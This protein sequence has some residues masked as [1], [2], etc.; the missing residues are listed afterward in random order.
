[1]ILSLSI[2]KKAVPRDG[3][4]VHFIVFTDIRKLLTPRRFGRRSDMTGENILIRQSDS[5]PGPIF[6][7]SHPRKGPMGLIGCKSI[8]RNTE[9]EPQHSYRALTCFHTFSPEL[10]PASPGAWLFVPLRR[11]APSAPRGDTKDRMLYCV[12]PGR[13]RSRLF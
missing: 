6:D 5:P 1:V 12:R 3:P 10:I 11:Q 4:L 2:K 9:N 8:D 13:L 7:V